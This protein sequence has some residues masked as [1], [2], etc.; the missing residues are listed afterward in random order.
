MKLLEFRGFPRT[1]PLAIDLAQTEGA[2]DLH[3]A[4]RVANIRRVQLSRSA[5]RLLAGIAS[6]LLLLSQTVV[7]VE[8]CVAAVPASSTNAAQST[9]HESGSPDGS[10]CV[11]DTCQSHCMSQ[12]GAP[13]TASVAVPTT[14]GL[15]AMT[16]RLDPLLPVEHVAQRAKPLLA[17]RADSPPLTILHCCLR[18]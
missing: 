4:H 13:V 17:A 14:S 11:Y 15:P 5:R 7:A 16:A 6:A 8:A 10:K 9:C 3:T 12:H 18:N 1:G 2:W